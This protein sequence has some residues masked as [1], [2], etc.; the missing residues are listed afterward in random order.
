MRKFHMLCVFGFH[1]YRLLR[2]EKKWRSGKQC[3]RC[4]KLV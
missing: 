2:P 3:R 1:N 4:L